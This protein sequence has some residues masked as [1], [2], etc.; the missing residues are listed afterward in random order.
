MKLK[1]NVNQWLIANYPP[2]ILNTFEVSGL[3]PHELKLKVG[4]IIILSKNIDTRQGLCNGTRLIITALTVIVIVADIASGKNVN[5]W[6]AAT[7]FADASGSGADAARIPSSVTQ[8][9]GSGPGAGAPAAAREVLRV[10]SRTKERS[11]RCISNVAKQDYISAR[12]GKIPG[13]LIA[14]VKQFSNNT[15]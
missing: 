7:N 13:F 6:I 2:K 4:A 14:A 3:P 9:R 15:T 11:P 5:S 8:A 10:S 12:I 1:D